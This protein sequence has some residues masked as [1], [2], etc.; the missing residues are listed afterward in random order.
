MPRGSRSLS[1]LT[2]LVVLLTAFLPLGC[3]QQA[4]DG[5][6][7]STASIGRQA[8]AQS[9]DWSGESGASGHPQMTAAAIRNA[10]AN[11]DQCLQR[12]AP[13]AERRGV[14]RATYQAQTRGLTPDL[15]I[16]DL[17]DAQPEFTKSFWEYLDLLVNEERI[18]RGR[19]ILAQHRLSFD[20]AEKQYGV[21][22]HIIAAI[23]GI[24]SKYSTM[25]GERSVVRST[26][27]LACI[28]RRQDYFR[29]EFIAA[30]ELLERG[31]VSAEQLKGSWA[32]AFGP[33]QFMPS[34]YRNYAVDF[35]GDR[36]R[37]LVGS[38]PDLLASTANYLKRN[39]WESG[40][41]WGY[42]VVVPKNF[43]YMLADRSRQLTLHEWEQRGI[44]RPG[45]KPFPRASERAYL[46]VPAGSQGPGFLMLHNFRVIMRY[47]PSEAYALAIGHLADRLRGGEALAQTWPRHERVLTLAERAEMQELL[48]R[49]GYEVGESDGR[50]GAKTRAA[51][52]QFQAAS[53]LVPDGFASETVLVRLRG[54]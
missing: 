27:T 5:R 47:N 46:L 12:M 21:D 18:A 8:F 20:A 40:Q 45:G 2:G 4:V 7:I 1:P 19:E 9:S 44:R 24:E 53:G 35:D 34:V 49:R 51:I 33:T 50:F 15:K 39:G 3:A 54:S 6:A 11:F 25:I 41:S 22:R 43:D 42:E 16:M 29:N 36:R 38:I 14:S 37:D 23:W 52:R 26:A 48:A 32:G 10:A 17:V 28:G 31:D 30:L 13:D